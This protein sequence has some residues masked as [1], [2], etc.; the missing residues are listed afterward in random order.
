MEHLSNRHDP[1]L[2][3]GTENARKWRKLLNLRHIGSGEWKGREKGFFFAR[4][5]LPKEAKQDRIRS[6][7]LRALFFFYLGLGS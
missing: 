3:T 1:S 6:V 7:E 5:G 4:K 2:P